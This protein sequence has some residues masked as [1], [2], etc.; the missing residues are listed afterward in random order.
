M[1]SGR[2]KIFDGREVA[3]RMTSLESTVDGQTT[4]LTDS[5]E[6]FKSFPEHRI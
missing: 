2:E 1:S 4:I 3:C 5:A 6:T